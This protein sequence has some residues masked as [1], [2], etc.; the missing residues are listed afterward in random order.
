MSLL[1]RHQKAY[2]AMVYFNITKTQL[3]RII[4]NVSEVLDWVG[5]SL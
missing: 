4:F 5:V 3:N 1:L 2:F